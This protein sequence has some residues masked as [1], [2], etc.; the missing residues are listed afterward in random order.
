M[1]H[2]RDPRETPRLPARDLEA[3]AFIGRGWEVA[4]YQLRA[5]IFPGVSEVVASRRVR[6]WADLKLIRVERF[7]GMGVNL[8]RLAPAGRELLVAAKI[9]REDEL[10]TPERSAA[11]KDIRHLLSVNDVRTLAVMGVPWVADEIAPA[12]FLQRRHQP[13]PPAVPDVLLQMAPRDGKRG[14]LLAIEIDMGGERL[15][16]TLF[17]KL[18]LLAEVLYA[19]AGGSKVAVI[20]LTRGPR[21]LEA[22][23]L[24]LAQL[25]LPVPVE[26]AELPTATGVGALTRLRE[27]L[28]RPVNSN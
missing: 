23:R 1:L 27:L 20:I 7:L 9:A 17:P 25:A 22:M 5:A 15:V 16:A 2:M 13:P 3:L 6:R 8:L 18:Q 4:Q 19:W 24:G 28:G 10:F 12:W 26:A 11:L 14:K 21:R